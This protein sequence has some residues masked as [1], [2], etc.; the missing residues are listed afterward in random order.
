LYIFGY[1][2]SSFLKPS[3]T[4][5]FV[6]DI[7]KS[8]SLDGDS[9]PYLLYT[10]ARIKS[11]LRKNHESRIMNQGEIN[12]E[13]EKYLIVSKAEKLENLEEEDLLL[14][15]RTYQFCDVVSFAVDTLSP[16]LICNYLYD[17][18]KEFNSY[19]QKVSILKA[20]STDLVNARI[21]LILAVSTVLKEGLR[22]LDIETVEKM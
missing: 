2:Q 6:F 9:G 12:M 7:Q 17:L 21:S 20:S 22:L 8:I 4:S 14:L 11:I 19:Y 13:N 5:G 3:P 10:Y 1:S 16:S 15:R 18:A